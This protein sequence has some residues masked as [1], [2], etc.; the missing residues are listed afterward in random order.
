MAHFVYHK[1]LHAF[2]LCGPGE[3]PRGLSV[4]LVLGWY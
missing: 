2:G 4:I 3:I 1:V